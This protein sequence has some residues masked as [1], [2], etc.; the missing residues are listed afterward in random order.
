MS[1]AMMQYKL[2]QR[3]E[4]KMD[5]FAKYYF[6]FNEKWFLM[7]VWTIHYLTLFILIIDNL[8]SIHSIKEENKMS[9]KDYG[10]HSKSA[11]LKPIKHY[12]TNINFRQMVKY[13]NP[14][15]GMTPIPVE[16]MNA[17]VGGSLRVS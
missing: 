2:L 15:N 13:R 6:Q 4:T 17:T 5:A 9:L 10:Q 11:L 16:Q 3:V 7:W 1:E 14:A 8:I 12:K